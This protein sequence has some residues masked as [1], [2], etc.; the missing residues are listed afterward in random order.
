VTPG[1]ALPVRVGVRRAAAADLPLALV[2]AAGSLSAAVLAPW[3]PLFARLLPACPLHAWTG[4]PC[5]GCGATRAALALTRGDL[6]GAL[7]HN[8][9]VALGLVGLLGAGALAPLWVWARGPLPVAHGV[10]A[11]LLRAT[12]AGTLLANWLWLLARGT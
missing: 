5:P 10:P 8:P 9:L 1:A 3:A 6:A 2:L 11:N 7:A 4:L 12:I